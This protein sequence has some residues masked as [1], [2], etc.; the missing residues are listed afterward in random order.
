VLKYLKIRIYDPEN[1]P[2][3]ER[4]WCYKCRIRVA[5]QQSVNPECNLCIICLLKENKNINRAKAIKYEFEY[6][7]EKPL[8][9]LARREQYHEAQR[10]RWQYK[11]KQWA[12]KWIRMDSRL[13]FDSKNMVGVI[14]AMIPQTDNSEENPIEI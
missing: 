4:S 6:R 9:F 14:Y 3:G 10:K 5:L 13:M 11:L 7:H 2:I 8:A 1:R 12:K